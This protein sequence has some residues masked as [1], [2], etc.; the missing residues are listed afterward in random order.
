MRSFIVSLSILLRF[1][2]WICWNA[3]Q[4]LSNVKVLQ[5]WLSILMATRCSAGAESPYCSH[6]SPANQA[7]NV[8]SRIYWCWMDSISIKKA[9]VTTPLINAKPR[10][11]HKGK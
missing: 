1:S 2:E 9:K 6:Q 8:E 3:L 11:K 4:F 5:T 7:S 10:R